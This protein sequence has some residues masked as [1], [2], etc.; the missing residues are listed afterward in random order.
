MRAKNLWHRSSYVFIEK[1]GKFLVQKRTATK[2][3]CPSY[4]GLATGGVVSP[5]ESAALNAARELKEEVGV[6]RS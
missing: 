2:E 6:T 3:Y 4:W 5:D 1:D